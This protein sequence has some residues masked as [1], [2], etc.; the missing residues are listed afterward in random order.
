M[1]FPC[2]NVILKYIYTKYNLLQI[3]IFFCNKNLLP[4]ALTIA[5]KD[6][7]SSEL[8]CSKDLIQALIKS[9]VNSEAV[10]SVNSSN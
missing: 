2:I 1:S 10:V 4:S 7:K 8:T 9:S 3:G 5:Y 6:M